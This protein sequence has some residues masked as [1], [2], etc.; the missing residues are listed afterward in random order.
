VNVTGEEEKRIFKMIQDDKVL[1]YVQA[2][3]SEGF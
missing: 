1:R 2:I 3:A